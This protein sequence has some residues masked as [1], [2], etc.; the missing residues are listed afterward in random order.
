MALRIEEVKRT[1]EVLINQNDFRRMLEA[2]R[3]ELLS[4]ATSRDEILIENAAE[5]FDR[6]QQQLNREV[7]IRNLDRT[8][9]LL[10]SV[11]AALSR[12]DDK[13]YAVCLRCDEQIPD[14]RLKAVPWTGYCVAC[15][16]EID[17]QHATGEVEDDSYITQLAA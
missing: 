16:E 13:T 7:A 4:D 5:E 14:K 11:Q 8:S 10:K 17:R 12:I 6:L 15:Q 1:K 3:N 9:K 2:K